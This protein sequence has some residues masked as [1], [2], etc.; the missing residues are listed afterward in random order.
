MRSACRTVVICLLFAVVA[1]SG[2]STQGRAGGPS[3][4]EPGISPDGREVAFVSG[5]DVWTAPLG[6]ASAVAHL[7]VSHP[8]TESRPLYSPTGQAIAFVSTRTGNGDIYVLR[9]GDASLTRLTFDDGAEMLDGWSRDGRWIYFSSTTRDIAGMNDVFRISIDG[10]TPMPVTN[11]RYTNEYFSAQSPDGRTLAFSARGIASQQW[12]RNG[13]SHIDQSEIWLAADGAPPASRYQRI[14]DRGAKALWPMWAGDGKSIFYMS[15]RSGSENIW[16]AAIGGTARQLTRF[17]KGRVLWPS[18]TTDGRTIAFE[19][20]FGI[21]TLDTATGRTSEVKPGL[22][23]AAAA[24]PVEHQ[25]FT[26]QFSDLSLSPDGRKVAFIVR[27]EVFA[28]S[29]KESGDAER[30]TTTAARE[31]GVTWAPDSRRLFYVSER[32]GASTLVGFDFGTRAET[33]LT[34]SPDELGTPVVSPDGKFVAYVQARKELK[35]LAIDSKQARTVAT[36]EFLAG[37]EAANPLEWSPNSEWVA[38]LSR[39]TRGFYNVSVVAAA[40]AKPGTA[41]P[42]SFLANLNTDSLAWSPDG[43]F[44]TFATGQRT[45]PGQVARVDLVLRTPKF[46]EDRFRSLFDQETPKP[47]PAT[48][49]APAA[50]EPA[51]PAATPVAASPAPA[52][53]FDD[54]RRRLSVIPVGVDVQ[55]QAISPDGKL[56]LVIA[57]AAGQTNLY[58]YSIDE[59]S[60]EPAVARQLTSTAGNKSDAQFSSD[61]KEVYY[62]DAGRPHSITVEDRRVRPLDLTAEMDTDFAREKPAVFQQAWRFLNDYF[63]DASHNGADWADARQTYGARVQYARTPDE[64]RRVTQ[65]M[66]GELNASHL[67]FSAP[68]G[69]ATP[70][71]TGRIGVRFDPADYA[72]GGRLRIAEILPLG[73]VAVT[74]AVRVG[75]VIVAVDGVRLTAAANFDERM[76]HTIGRRVVL[77][78]SSGGTDKDVVVRPVNLATEKG[79]L[80]R[81][82]VEETRALVGTLSNNRLG[83]AHMPDMSAQ[84]LE[85]FFIDLD[86]DN[87]GKDGVVIDV[88]NNNG[89]FV[90]VYAIDMLA[91]RSYFHM[92]P[93]DSSRVPSRSVLGQRALERPTVLVTNQHSLSD[94][95][96]FTEG[97]RSLKLGTVVG[98]PTAGWIIFTWNTPMMDGSVLRLPRI[99]ITAADGSDMEMHPRPVDLPVTRAFGES[100]AGRDSQIEAAVKQLLAQITKS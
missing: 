57:N 20:D 96:D 63:F 70:A 50:T 67:G 7:L 3:L 49:S 31:F 77:G 97:Y 73:P 99:R 66:I 78:I 28:G 21:W 30:V 14:V 98:E 52:L 34:T 13:H 45:E 16:Q 19:R 59:L 2:I 39:G 87:L 29:A 24:P 92:T 65:L 41:R 54:I 91:R 5:G 86:A 93:R 44:L 35:V 37:F 55:D 23:G 26:N 79:L 12:W 22:R 64:M 11:E 51:A 60:R 27:G 33:A 80:Y 100:A 89:G 94:A 1:T 74:G 90:N 18:I 47:K 69:Q 72:A 6:G 9:F 48:P 38:F 84:S 40:A 85:Q 10:G 68:P 62:L 56:L 32:D 53:V 58:T 95:E 81:S 46:R 43:T 61:G 4:A 8:A 88:R 82:W 25:R 17:A 15:D 36:G 83:Y 76:Q 75:D 71:F 42:V